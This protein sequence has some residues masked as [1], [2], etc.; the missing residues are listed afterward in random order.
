[1]SL[2]LSLE[3]STKTCS[4]ALHQSGQLLAL[5]ELQLGHSHS[6]MLTVL[7]EN[8]L[9]TTGFVL[10]DLAAIAV[11]KGPGSYTGLRIGI[12][13][14]KGL[15]YALDI[16]IIGVN[17]LESMV[18]AIQAKIIGTYLYCPMIDARRMEVYCGIWDKNLNCYAPTQA[19]IIDETAFGDIL[20]EK[21]LVFFGDGAQKCQTK[22][23]SSK[24]A[25]FINDFTPTAQALGSLAT[26]Q[27][28]QQIFEDLAYFEPFYLK[29]FVGKKVNP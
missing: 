21:A 12:A 14:A 20:Q 7:I 18:Y 1:L 5:S 10:Q 15:S 9:K 27:F 29:D 17:T 22:L 19:K 6:E 26:L 24:N 23:N 2:I 28:E 13:T 4:V 16:P 3:T 25:Y 8:L 11:A